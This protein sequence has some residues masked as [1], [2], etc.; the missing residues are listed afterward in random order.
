[1]DDVVACISVFNDGLAI[2]AAAGELELGG[3]MQTEVDGSC[4]VV[5]EI[6]LDALGLPV[7]QCVLVAGDVDVVGQ[8]LA[9]EFYVYGAA[10]RVFAPNTIYSFR[11]A[12]RLG[13]KLL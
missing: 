12:V 9:A 11:A 4:A 13:M 2:P 3:Q 10:T 7:G 1:M 8:M 6:H 5:D